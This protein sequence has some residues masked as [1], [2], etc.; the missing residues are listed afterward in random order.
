MFT[1]AKCVAGSFIVAR[2]MV[3]GHAATNVVRLSPGGKCDMFG[4]TPYH[5]RFIFHCDVRGGGGV[6]IPVEAED[7][8]TAWDVFR[9]IRAQLKLTGTIVDCYHVDMQTIRD[10]VSSN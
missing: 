4:K 1:S 8:R 9:E 3:C 6:E 10:D 5:F 7:M 2:H